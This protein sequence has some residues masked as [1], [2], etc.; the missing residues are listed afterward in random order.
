MQLVWNALD[1]LSYQ[2]VIRHD[3][4]LNCSSRD[5]FTDKYLSYDHVVTRSLSVIHLV[6]MLEDIF[7]LQWLLL[8]R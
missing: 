3:Q 4:E 2:W 1:E 6:P 5:D 8:Y 7:S